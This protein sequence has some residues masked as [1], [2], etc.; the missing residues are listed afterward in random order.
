M[1]DKKTTAGGSREA[2]KT[3]KSLQP[4]IIFCNRKRAKRGEPPTSPLP[5][6]PWLYCPVEREVKRMFSSER[7]QKLIKGFLKWKMVHC[8]ALSNRDMS[9]IQLWQCYCCQCWFDCFK[10]WPESA[11]VL[12]YSWRATLPVE[13]SGCCLSVARGSNMVTSGMGLGGTCTTGILS[14]AGTKTIQIT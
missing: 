2:G 1:G 3:R 9:V 6:N 12:G 14:W 4:Y 11:V 7:S 8:A 5:H 13:L 10:A